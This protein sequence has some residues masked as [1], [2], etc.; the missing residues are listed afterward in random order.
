VRI[1]AHDVL[2]LR[3]TQKFLSLYVPMFVHA[4]ERDGRLHAFPLTLATVT[5]RMALPGVP[6]QTAPKGELE[7]AAENGTLTAAIRSALV[8]E[9]G[10]PHRQRRLR[11]DGAP[12]RRRT[13]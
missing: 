9:Q 11:H 10:E 3:T 5:G 2:A 4:A 13:L 8:A 7:L 1:G 6:L 12:H